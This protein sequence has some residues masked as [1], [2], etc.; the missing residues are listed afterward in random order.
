M[1]FSS[2]GSAAAT[3]IAPVPARNWRRSRV[4]VIFAAAWIAATI[5]K[6]VPQRQRYGFIAR[7]I[8]SS[9]GS[10]FEANSASAATIIPFVQ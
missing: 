1:G 2:R 3:N 8:S 9:L 4:A 5:R 6:W 10:G 7:L